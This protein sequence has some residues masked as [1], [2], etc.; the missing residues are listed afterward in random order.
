MKT[1]DGDLIKLALE[2][3]FDVI[4]HGCN[5][6]NRMGAGIALQI[7]R[8]FPDAFAQDKFYH[9]HMRNYMGRCSF[10]HTSEPTVIN[11]YTQKNIYLGGYGSGDT[12]ID[13][14]N[15]IR[16][17]FRKLNKIFNGKNKRIGIPK[18]GAGLAGGNWSRIKQIIEEETPDIDITLVNY[19]RK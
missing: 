11:A 8:T 13:R 14:E 19:K 18:I 7:K 3:E 10:S 12:L 5:C 1:V 16:T 4:V 6:Q 17:V 2:G 15:A 9:H